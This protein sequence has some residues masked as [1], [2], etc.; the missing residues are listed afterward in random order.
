MKLL[1][2]V[3]Q[4]LPAAMRVQYEAAMTFAVPIE[5]YDHWVLNV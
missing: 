2:A 4:R 5:R 3:G 1:R